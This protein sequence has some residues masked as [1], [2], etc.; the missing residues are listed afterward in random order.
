MLEEIEEKNENFV[1]IEYTDTESEKLQSRT[2]NPP[3]I[4]TNARVCLFLKNLKN[5]N[6]VGIQNESKPKDNSQCY[7]TRPVISANEPS[8]EVLNRLN[9]QP[10]FEKLTSVHDEKLKFTPKRSN[11]G[12]FLDFSCPGPHFNDNKAAKRQSQTFSCTE[13]YYQKTKTLN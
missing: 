12:T 2:K 1:I 3:L 13:F 6:V 5:G 10:N 11:F 8:S 9:E 4:D 7:N